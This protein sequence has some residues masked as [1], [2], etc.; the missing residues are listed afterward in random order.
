MPLMRHGA[1]KAYAPHVERMGGQRPLPKEPGRAATA[2]IPAPG[3]PVT[4]ITSPT[5]G[6]S[7]LVGAAR[8]A[9]QKSEVEGEGPETLMLVIQAHA[10]L[11]IAAEKL[12]APS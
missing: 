4:T 1:E 3:G 2:D 6:A 12:Q 8:D 7:W 5:I 9:L 11:G 10:L